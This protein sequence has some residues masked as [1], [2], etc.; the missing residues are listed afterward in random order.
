MLFDLYKLNVSEG[1]QAQEH[2]LWTPPP[3]KFTE[4]PDNQLGLFSSETKVSSPLLVTEE[5]QDW[6]SLVKH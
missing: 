5:V 6:V 4:T 3:T 2:P 1:D